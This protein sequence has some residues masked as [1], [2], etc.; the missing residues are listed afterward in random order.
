MNIMHSEDIVAP[1]RV[2]PAMWS[3][4]TETNKAGDHNTK[5]LSLNRVT[6]ASGIMYMMV[7]K[8]IL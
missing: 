4:W 6:A 7:E 5:S 3:L 1:C 8:S 2:E